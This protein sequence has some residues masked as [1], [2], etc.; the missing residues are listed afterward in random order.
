MEGMTWQADVD[1]DGALNYG[2]FVAVSIHLKKIANDE[3]LRRAFTYFDLN[4][5][6]YIEIEEL[7]E[8]L[9]DDLGVNNEEVIKSI[10]LD[11]DTDRVSF[12]STSLYFCHFV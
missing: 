2:E 11:V 6:G 9:V 8:A 12:H 1:G 5:S 10:I 7:R 4:N 3:H